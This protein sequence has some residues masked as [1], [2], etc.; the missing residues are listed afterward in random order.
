MERYTP[1]QINRAL[2]QE[3]LLL[4]LDQGEDFEGLCQ[5]L[6]LSLSRNYLPQLRRRYQQGG[7]TWG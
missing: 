7:S 1:S 5:E 6:G 2:A 3:Q 4:R